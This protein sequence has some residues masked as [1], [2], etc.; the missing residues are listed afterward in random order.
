MTLKYDKKKFGFL[1][2]LEPRECDL[3]GR[4]AEW[5]VHTVGGVELYLCQKHKVELLG[6]DEKDED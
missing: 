6:P 5:S 3:C 4:K 1:Q 2:R